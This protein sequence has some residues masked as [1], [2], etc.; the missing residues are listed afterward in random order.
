MTLF[1]PVI[2]LD[3]LEKQDSHGTTAF[4]SKLI[5]LVDGKIANHGKEKYLAKPTNHIGEL[6]L[7][8]L[9]HANRVEQLF[10]S[11]LLNVL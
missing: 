6:S 8:G 9:F 10:F 11:I 5:V 1:F 2:R 7:V 3:I 4:K